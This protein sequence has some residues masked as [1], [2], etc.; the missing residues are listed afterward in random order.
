[1]NDFSFTVSVMMADGVEWEAPPFARHIPSVRAS[2]HKKGKKK[3][4]I[5]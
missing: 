3:K 1:M 2:N 5:S 4:F